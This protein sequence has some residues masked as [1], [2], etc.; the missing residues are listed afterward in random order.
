MRKSGSF[1]AGAPLVPLVLLAGCFT[2]VP[3]PPGAVPG[4]V[5]RALPPPSLE[6]DRSPILT[7]PPEAPRDPIL[8]SRWAGHPIITRHK[9][10]WIDFWTGRGA[11]DFQRYL[12]R[13]E[14]YRELVDEEIARLGLPP[15]LRYLP[16]VESG[17]APTARSRARAVGLWQ[18]MSGTARE[19]GL[20]VS[21]LLDERRDPVRSTR[22]ALGLLAEHRER[23]GSWYLALA[24]YNGGPNRLSRILRRRA[25][26]APPGDSLFLVAYE[27]LPR[28]TRDF[29]PKLLAA[30]TLAEAPQRY[31]FETP[32]RAPSRFD[33]VTVPDATSVDVIAEAAASRQEVI[34]LLNPQLVRGFTPPG[35]ET[36]VRVPEGRGALFERNYPLIPPE[37]RVSYLEHR[38]RRGETLSHIA[39]RYGVSVQLIRAA[40][41][42]LVPHRLQIGQW[43]VVPR[44]PR[45]GQRAAADGPVG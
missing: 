8:E 30:S 42:D 41:P 28:E 17:Y 44:G 38:V 14:R 43:V 11:A 5:V 25:P 2:T 13:M 24:A 29:V 45:A 1:P 27:A 26:L 36:V 6:D 4:P 40:N 10:R 33:E 34:E 12:A 35:R 23:F 21:A 19:V 15:S 32:E 9:E 37:R 18:F 39:L 3:E 20:T 16:I 31:G 7:P 22:K